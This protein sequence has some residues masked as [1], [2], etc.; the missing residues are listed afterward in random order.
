MPNLLAKM[1]YEEDGVYGYLCLSCKSGISIRGTWSNPIAFCPFC[2]IKFEGAWI[3]D[4]SDKRNMLKCK[5]REKDFRKYWKLLTLDLTYHKDGT[6]FGENWRDDGEV[7]TGDKA[8]LLKKQ[9][10]KIKRILTDAET[11][12]VGW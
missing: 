3:K 2:G 4:G 5:A 11:E 8:S 9:K 12:I 6:P 7:F 10:D 1:G